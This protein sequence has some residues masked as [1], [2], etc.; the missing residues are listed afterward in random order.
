MVARKEPQGLVIVYTGNG[1]GKT[2]A[3]LGLILRAAGNGLRVFVLQFIKGQ[4]KTGESQTLKLLAP[5]VEHV[6]MGR[7]FTIERLRDPRIPMEEHETAAAAAFAHAAEVVRSGAYD[8]VVLD[9]LLGSIKADLVQLDD[10]LQLIRDKP[11]RL[12]LVLT[13]RGAPQPLIDAADLVTEMT[14]VKHPY[15]Q[16]IKAQRGI[17]F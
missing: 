9:E 2:T 3:A 13:G 17:E 15:E 5:N 7:G 8:M 10:V 11:P 12:H 1:K 6:R 14:P 16:G 4:W